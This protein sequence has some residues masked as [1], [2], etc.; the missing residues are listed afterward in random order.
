MRHPYLIILYAVLLHLTWCAALLYDSAAGRATAVHTLLDY[1]SPT[2]AAGIYF[3]VA[4]C[5]LLGFFCRRVATP[6]YLL[7]QQAIMMISAG[8]A[9]QAMWLGQFADGVQR[10]HAFLV[11]DQAPA[12]IG[13]F[14]HSLA[15]LIFL[16][17]S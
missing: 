11:A 10:S 7:P 4:G 13:A 5:A 3:A 8:G 16:R 17:E 9:L 2:V 14:L 6:Y 12:V 1:V 15:I